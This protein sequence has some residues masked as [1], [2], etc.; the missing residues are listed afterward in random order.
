MSKRVAKVK[1]FKYLRN[2]QPYWHIHHRTLVEFKYEPIKNRRDYIKIDKDADE[3]PTRLRLLKPVKGFIGDRRAYNNILK[4][5]LALKSC[6]KYS[7]SWYKNSEKYRK[8][9]RTYKNSVIPTSSSI[10]KQHNL[11]CKNCPWNGETIFP[12]KL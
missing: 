3:V 10:I 4:Y 11:E 9:C 1:K 2:L 6:K 5:G 12:G 8:A 7:P